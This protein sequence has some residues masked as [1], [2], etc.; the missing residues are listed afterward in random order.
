MAGPEEGW[1]L[2]PRSSTRGLALGTVRG[3]G[4]RSSGSSPAIDS[5]HQEDVTAPSSLSETGASAPWLSCLSMLC[6]ARAPALLARR[7]LGTQHHRPGRGHLP[8][9]GD[10]SQGI[11]HAGTSSF[12][13]LRSTTSLLQSPLPASCALPARFPRHRALLQLCHLSAPSPPLP[14]CPGIRCSASGPL[15][16]PLALVSSCWVPGG[17]GRGGAAPQDGSDWP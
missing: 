17:T 3:S 13:P 9:Q 12:S 16:E 4:S 2:A 14:P 11:L 7:G 10:I 8:G 6:Q 15:Q 5:C 1:L